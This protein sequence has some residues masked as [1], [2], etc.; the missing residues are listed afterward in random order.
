MIHVRLAE[1]GLLMSDFVECFITLCITIVAIIAIIYNK[2]INVKGKSK[3]DGSVEA[4]ITIDE[5]NKGVKK[6]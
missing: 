5:E 6:E 4:A 3:E 2:N 1:G